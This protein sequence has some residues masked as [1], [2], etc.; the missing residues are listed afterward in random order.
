MNVKNS[1]LDQDLV[2]SCESIPEVCVHFVARSYLKFF[3]VRSGRMVC[4]L[5]MLIEII[6]VLAIAW[7]GDESTNLHQMIH[8]LNSSVL[9]RSRRYD[10]SGFPSLTQ[11]ACKSI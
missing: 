5:F 11:I 10:F 8:Q 6:T 7:Q 9:S 4:L 3:M 2:E 1:C